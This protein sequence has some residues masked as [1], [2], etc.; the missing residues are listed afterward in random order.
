MHLFMCP[1]HPPLFQPMYL[2]HLLVVMPNRLLLSSL[3]LSSLHLY[4]Q[5][6]VTEWPSSSPYITS[7]GATDIP[8]GAKKEQAW[9]YSGGGFSGCV[10]ERC[11]VER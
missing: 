1:F 3:L 9:A 4:L 7:V 2:F 11:D 6:F 5:Q 8:A 10:S